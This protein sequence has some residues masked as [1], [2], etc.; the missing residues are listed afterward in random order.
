MVYQATKS[1]V[2]LLPDAVSSDQA[3]ATVAQLAREGT[4][5]FHTFVI[6]ADGNTG[7][8]EEVTVI[9]DPVKGTVTGLK[10]YAEE[11]RSIPDRAEGR[12][13]AY[14]IEAFVS[15]INR[16]K[17]DDQTVVF[18]KTQWPPSM[19]AMIDYHGRN[20]KDPRWLRHSIRYD[21]PVTEGF[22]AWCKGN[23]M[24][25]SQEIF[26]GFIEERI[27]ELATATQVETQEYEG[28]FRTKVANP[29]E[30]IVLSRGLSFHVDRIVKNH[31]VLAT[32][33]GQIHFEESHKGSDGKP[34]LVPGIFM[35]SLPIFEGGDPVRFPVRLRYRIEENR[36]VWSYSLYEWKAKAKERI[37]ADIAWVEDQCEVPVYEGSPEER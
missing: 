37:E 32:G 6:D 13:A 16:H 14:T 19:I 27:A 4:A 34:L 17:V 5:A 33:E 18:A 25:L 11:W 23:G 20:G 30:M 12:A 3:I 2:N 29:S 1:G 24:K 26:C 31:V 15:M 22:N 10:K 9:Y 28:L 35:I 7:L 21:F 36:M 8:P